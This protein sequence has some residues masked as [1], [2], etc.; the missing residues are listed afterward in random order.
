MTRALSPE[1]TDA[2]R[3]F[4]FDSGV[5]G[6]VGQAMGCEEIRFYFDY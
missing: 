1:D 2:V 6:L 5:A 4:V 3:S